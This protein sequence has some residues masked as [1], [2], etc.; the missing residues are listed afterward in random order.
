MR[1][2]RREKTKSQMPSRAAVASDTRMT[3]EVKL[4]VCARVGQLTWAIS[5]RVSMMYWVKRFIVFGDLY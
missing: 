2:S 4:I 5:A 1:V 3:M